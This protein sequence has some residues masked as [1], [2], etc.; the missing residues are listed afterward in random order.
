M[1]YYID[2]M[3]TNWVEASSKKVINSVYKQKH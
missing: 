1:Q 3:E 2:D